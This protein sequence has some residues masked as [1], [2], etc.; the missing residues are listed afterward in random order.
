MISSQRSVFLA[1]LLCLV[2]TGSRDVW[3]ATDKELDEIQRIRVELDEID[4]LI[5]A[6]NGTREWNRD[7]LNMRIDSRTLRTLA[8]LHRL[9]K[10]VVVDQKL[11]EDV[12]R[13]LENLIEKGFAL[14]VEREELLEARAAQEREK[15]PKFEKSAQADIARVFIDDLTRLRKDYLELVIQQVAIREAAGM[16]AESLLQFARERISVVMEYLSGQ[17][18]LDAMSLGELRAQRADEPLDEDV[19]DAFRLVQ[20]KQRRNLHQLDLAVDLAERVGLPVAE[21]QGL[22]VRERGE[23]GIELLRS[24]VFEALWADQFSKLQ[25]SFVRNGPDFLFRFLLFSVIL[26]I[27]WVIA[28]L[29]RGLVKRVVR[30][31]RFGLSILVRDTLT[32]LSGVAVLAA[33]AIIALATIGVSLGP[34]FAGIGVIGILVGLAVQDSLSNLAAGVMILINR[35]FD[36]DDHIQVAGANGVVKRMNWLA[37]KITTFDNQVLVVPNRRIWGDTIINFTASHVR[38]VDVKVSFA[39][40]ED[41][42]RVHR[43]LMDVLEQHPDVLEKPEPQVHMVAME[44]SAVAM[45]VKPWVRTEHY[46]PTLW[47]LN[48]G[49]KKR[50]DAEGIEIPFPQRVVTLLSPEERPRGPQR[51]ERGAEETPPD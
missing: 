2:T 30:H 22:L 20:A 15:I 48:R 5:E 13:T 40:A 21:Q 39:Y 43:V 37:T 18:T 24:D 6:V 26:L 35:P 42:D 4:R 3:S 32:V 47:D 36:I 45:V 28:R 29:V 10:K 51:A 8:R 46:W 12:K 7:G 9:A 23:V 11:D 16:E 38:R 25:Q 27:S 17:V 41:S 34:I 31:S 50:F 44:D 49:I 1:V 33:G 19:K 14:S